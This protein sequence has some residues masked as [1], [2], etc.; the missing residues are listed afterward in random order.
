MRIWK[1]RLTVTDSQIILMPRGAK[2]LDVQ[3]VKGIA[4]I[5]ALCDPNMECEARQ[6]EIYGTGNIVP[7]NPGTYIGTFQ[8][9]QGELIFHVFES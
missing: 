5:W 2:I 7:D 3:N 9:A 4:S 1:W 8:I 6:I